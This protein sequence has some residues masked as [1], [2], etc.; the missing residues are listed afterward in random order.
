MDNLAARKIPNEIARQI[1]DVE[2]FEWSEEDN[3]LT[4]IASKSKQR[5]GVYNLTSLWVLL[6][7]ANLLFSFWLWIKITST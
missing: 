3:T 7:W 5:R 6:S 4:P 1:E 2:L